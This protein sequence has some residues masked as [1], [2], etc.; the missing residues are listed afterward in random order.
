MVDLEVQLPQPRRS[1]ATPSSPR[2]PCTSKLSHC[3]GGSCLASCWKACDVGEGS[4]METNERLSGRNI[5]HHLPTMVTMGGSIS[6]FFVE[7][8]PFTS[9]MPGMPVL[10]LVQHSSHWMNNSWL[11]MVLDHRYL[12]SLIGLT[13]CHWY[14][15]GNGWE[16]SMTTIIPA[17]FPGTSQKIGKTWQK[18]W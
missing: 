4:H 17:S 14:I 11:G 1:A 10:S 7:S 8:D 15:V 2:R 12:T 18:T 9:G 6:R 16:W 3:S 13:G 5:C